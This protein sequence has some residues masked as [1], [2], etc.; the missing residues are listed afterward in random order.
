[1][2]KIDTNN[3]E[4]NTEIIPEIK[5]VTLHPLT[6][7]GET[8]LE[9]NLYPKTLLDGIVDRE[10]NA[11]KVQEKLISG[12]TIK[13]ING[14]SVLGDGNIET[15]D[16]YTKEESDEKFLSKE[17]AAETYETI[18]GANEKFATKEELENKADDNSVVHLNGNEIINGEKT[19]TDSVSFNGD[20]R[21]S[22]DDYYNK[23][24]HIG[25]DDA[26]MP[27]LYSPSIV[28]DAIWAS[29]DNIGIKFYA[30][31]NKNDNGYGLDI[32]D[33]SD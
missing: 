2:D 32:P 4:L 7:E 31:I 11:V 17:A 20:F 33:T 24:I 26:D 6:A 25:H 23:N 14:E 8:D 21:I 10:G 28:T 19:F 1:M 9:V 12:E 29:N 22:F 15:V 27:A 30:T 5:R 18:I 3:N 13:T 16:A